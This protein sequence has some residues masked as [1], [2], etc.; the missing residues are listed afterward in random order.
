M[1]SN[2]EFDFPIGIAVNRSDEILVTDHYNHRVQKFDRTG[3]FLSTFKVLPNPGGIALDT[4]GNVYVSHFQASKRSAITPHRVSVYS[5]GG[6]Q[7]HEWGKTGTGPGEFS[8]PGGLAVAPD[9]RVYV[10]DQT[11]HRVQVL[12]PDGQFLTTWGKYGTKPGEF[13]GKTSSLSRAAGPDFLT[14]DR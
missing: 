13:A 5:P 10:A 4:A 12:R 6:K 11:N 1:L 14:L 2:G 9:G 8:Y 7:L 3:K